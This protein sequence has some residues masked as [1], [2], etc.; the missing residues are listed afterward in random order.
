MAAKLIVTT[1]RGGS[2][3]TLVG[4]SGTELL[5]SKVFTEPRG[6]GATLRSLKGLLGED[7]VVEDRT[8]VASR[9]GADAAAKA[10]VEEPAATAKPAAAA[11]PAAK[12]AAK[13]AAKASAKKTAKP[14]AKKAAKPAAKRAAK[15]VARRKATAS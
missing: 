11:K 5:T 7:I 6:K 2:R 1:A 14:A 4:T 3:I 13:P 10:A 8:T 15:P 12:K 9:R